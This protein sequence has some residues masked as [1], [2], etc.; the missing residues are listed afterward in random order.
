[1]SA[2]D[3]ELSAR[4]VAIV[5]AWK[6]KPGALLPILHAV[7]DA[8][9][10]VPPES[11]PAIAEG[12]NLSRAEVHGVVSFYHYFRDTPPGRRT[13]QL[14]RAEA[15]QSMDARAL[16]AHVQKRLG[17]GLHQTTPD[18]EYSLE[19]VYCL[20]QCACSPA[21][22]IDGDVHGRVTPDR[23]DRLVSAPPLA[24]G[25]E[26]PTGAAAATVFVP[27]DSGAL[28][29]GA[30]EVRA[31]VAAEAAARNIQVRIVRNGS[32][33]ML[34]GAADRS[35]DI[36]WTP[37]LR[38]GVGRRWPGCSGRLSTGERAR[39][40]AGHRRNSV[41]KNQERLTFARVGV[42][43]PISLDDYWPA[44]R[45]SWTSAQSPC[46][47][48]DC[49]NG[50]STQDSAARRRGVSPHQMEDRP[51]QRVSQKWHV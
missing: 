35:G 30:D 37:R 49:A 20:G 13:I 44:W 7:Q 15:C 28:A 1:M 27:G 50:D 22:M 48:G 11:V 19:A 41:L 18:G 43:D 32:R 10:Y 39:A 31:A 21:V 47:R 16:E 6:D 29:L 23:F 3:P 8:I 51:D 4:V 5:D 45:L 40:G 38:T 12:L 33:G 46:Q 42:T 24:T 14:C 9:G 26:V 25:H 2:L 34:G 17:I 36:V